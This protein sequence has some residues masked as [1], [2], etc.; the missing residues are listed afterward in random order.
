MAESWQAPAAKSHG[1]YSMAICSGGAAGL[2]DALEPEAATLTWDA[3]CGTVITDGKIHRGR[4]ATARAVVRRDG[5]PSRE[6]NTAHLVLL[7]IVV[8]RVHRIPRA[9]GSQQHLC[10]S[11]RHHLSC[12][13]FFV[14]RQASVALSAPQPQPINGPP[15]SY[16]GRLARGSLPS[17][18]LLASPRSPRLLLPFKPQTPT[19]TPASRRNT[20]SISPPPL[21]HFFF[22]PRPFSWS[23]F[24]QDHL[25]GLF[26]SSFHSRA[27]MGIP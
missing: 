18:A 26:A 12:H 13:L 15:P 5:T 14:C 4:Q 27:T 8:G 2:V 22:S 23:R 1:F 9:D 24:P 25:R 19:S 21:P 20:P 3:A 10:S 11:R 16:E 6:T 17:F 7:S